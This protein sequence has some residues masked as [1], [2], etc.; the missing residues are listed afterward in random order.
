MSNDIVS[1]CV[2]AGIGT[3]RGW[4]VLSWVFAGLGGAGL[5]WS[6]WSAVEGWTAARWPVVVGHITSSKVEEFVVDYRWPKQ[7]TYK[8]SVEY[9][10]R[11]SGTPHSGKRRR[12]G[13]EQF[14]YSS[15]AETRLARYQ[16]HTS[17]PVHYHPGDPSRSVLEPGIEF[18][19]YLWMGFYAAMFFA[20]LGIITRVI[21]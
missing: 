13:N 15:S 1:A 4:S 8:P 6:V 7:V 21:C 9:S 11:V 3:W 12:F 17:V 16:V 10:Y 2:L 18:Q 20:G 19:S 14:S 5:A